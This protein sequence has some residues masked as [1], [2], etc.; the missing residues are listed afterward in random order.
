MPRYKIK[1]DIDIL[2][3]IELDKDW[4]LSYNQAKALAHQM[5]VNQLW[6]IFHET[7]PR[8]TVEKVEKFS[9]QQVEEA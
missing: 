3:E 4:D 8:V 1:W 6:R 2:E 9:M 5:M 7:N